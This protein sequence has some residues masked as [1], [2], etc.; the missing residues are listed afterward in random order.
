M[1]YKYL[2]NLTK[3]SADFYVYGNIVDENK[4][5]LWTGEKSETAVDTNALKTELDSLNGVTDFNI[6][7]NSG[8]G[9]VFASSAMVTMLKRFRQNTGATIHAYI[10]GLCASAATYLAMVADDINIYRNSVLMIH[11]PMTFAYGNA[12]EL[13]HDIDT[14]NLIESGTMLPMYVAKAKEGITAEKIA[15]LVDNETWFSGNADDDMYI[16]NYFNVNALETVKDVQAC[17]TDLFRNYKHVPDKLKRPKQTKKPVEDRMLDYSAYENI[18]CS[19]K[20]DGG[21]KE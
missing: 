19:L 4:P 8:G 12:N 2:K 15:E 9:S 14:L 18:I 20:K 17:A 1:N 13:Q 6:Y 16:G 11:K 21:A 3:T 5:D 10:D 7:I